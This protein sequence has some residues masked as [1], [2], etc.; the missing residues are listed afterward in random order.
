MANS[1]NNCQETSLNLMRINSQALREV[2]ILPCNVWKHW[3][4]EGRWSHLQP[5]L[6]PAVGCDK[7]SPFPWHPT[8]VSGIISSYEKYFL[9]SGPTHKKKCSRIWPLYNKHSKTMQIK[10]KRESTVRGKNKVKP[11]IAMMLRWTN[12]AFTVINTLNSL[13]TKG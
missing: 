12:T 4:R 5:V 10:K 8:E 9:L 7:T 1:W 13:V 3:F 6:K 11:D 2:L